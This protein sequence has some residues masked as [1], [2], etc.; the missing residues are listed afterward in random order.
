MVINW[1]ETITDS[2]NRRVSNEGFLLGQGGDADDEL[3]RIWTANGMHEDA[4]LGQVDA[5]VHGLGFISVWGNDEDPQT[6]L[7]A[8]ESAHQMA[9]GVR[10]RHR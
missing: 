2:V 5:L 9:G 1:P 8:F 7:M 3:W 4:P 10:A 6:P